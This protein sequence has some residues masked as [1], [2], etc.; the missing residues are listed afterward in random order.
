MTAECDILVLAA[1]ENQ[2]TAE[3]ADKFKAKYILELAN[4]PVTPEADVILAEK[5]ITVIPDILANAGG[6]TVSYFEWYQNVNDE[7][8]TYDDVQEKL[9]KI[10]KDAYKDVT[11]NAAEYSCDM[12]TAA[13][14]TAMKRLE[15]LYKEVRT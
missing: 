15:G 7:K 10:M 4:G 9:V 3:N 11:G 6:V 8:W 5:G 1:L 14:I 2:V 13:F 12:R